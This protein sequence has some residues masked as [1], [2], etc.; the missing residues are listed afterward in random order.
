[1]ARKC[2]GEP[3]VALPGLD[4]YSEVL[5]KRCEV[6]KDEAARQVVGARNYTLLDYRVEA[7]SRPATPALIYPLLADDSE[8]SASMRVGSSRPSQP[9]VEEESEDLSVSPKMSA[10]TEMH[11]QAIW[12]SIR[13]AER[14]GGWVNVPPFGIQVDVKT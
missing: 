8:W 13:V 4:L 7:I 10:G 12:I 11:N 14:T 9:W 3:A 5:D 1:M 2:S 6:R